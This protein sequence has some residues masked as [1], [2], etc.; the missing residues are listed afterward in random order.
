MAIDAEDWA[1]GDFF[2]STWGAHVMTLI[3]TK[4]GRRQS[5]IQT[6][7]RCLLQHVLNGHYSHYFRIWSI[8]GIT[9]G[10][11]KDSRYLFQRED[12]CTIQYT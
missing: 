2:N 4:D 10:R 1:K 12:T 8:T 5:R 3:R 9:V 11:N 6:I 7:F